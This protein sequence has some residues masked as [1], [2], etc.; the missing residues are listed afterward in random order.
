MMT[1]LMPILV[2][3][4]TLTLTGPWGSYH[5]T[6]LHC[7]FTSDYILDRAPPHTPYHTNV[8]YPPRTPPYTFE[9]G[10]LRCQCRGWTENVGNTLSEVMAR[11]RVRVRVRVGARVRG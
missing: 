3:A 8:S 1:P 10:V 5:Q 2:L 4:V 7:K 6:C 11:V 9:P